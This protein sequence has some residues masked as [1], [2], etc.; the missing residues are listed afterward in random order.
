MVLELFFIV[1]WCF[2][3]YI[4]RQKPD[5]VFSLSHDNENSIPGGGLL[6]KKKVAYVLAEC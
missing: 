1:C 3:V 5:D 2:A 6:G 4:T